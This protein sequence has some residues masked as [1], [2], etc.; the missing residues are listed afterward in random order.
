MMSQFEPNVKSNERER[1]I[2]ETIKD[3]PD[4]H[5]NR[6]IGLLVPKYMA[7]TT[8]EKARDSLIEKEILFV[9]KKGNMK[10]YLPTP[11]YKEKSQ[12]R[13]EQNTNKAFH[14][15]KLKIKNLNVSFPHKDV[16]EK[17]LIGTMFLKS[18]L[19]T[20]TGFTILDSIK[21]PN[22]TLYR[23][24][25]LMI[26]QMISQL[27]KIIKNDDDY[28]LIFPTIVSYHQVNVPHFEP[29]N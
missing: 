3:N 6:L 29:E 14:D 16:D 15:I 13:L 4:L 9:K 18:L 1:I 28:E 26:Q 22:K 5:H 24:E 27:F 25:H 23:D 7:K 8:F 2:F 20:D 21:N 17:I 10:F 19:Q 12:Q 11:N